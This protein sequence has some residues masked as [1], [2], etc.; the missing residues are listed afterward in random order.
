MS[1]P[2]VE[3]SRPL[4]VDTIGAAPRRIALAAEPHEREAL[5][6]RF[7]LLGLDRLEASLDVHRAGAEIVVAGRFAAEATQA[8]VATGEPV[9]S[10]LDEP[11]ALRFRPA[12]EVPPGGDAEIELEAAELDVVDYEGGTIDLGEAVAESLALALDPY[13]RSPAA[14]AALKQAG[15]LDEAEAGPFAAL[16]GLRDRLKK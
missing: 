8:C 14:A 11:L 4:R 5:A 15:V 9:A 7:G 3:L 1:A 6:R 13:P 16:A 10:A 2:A 12:R